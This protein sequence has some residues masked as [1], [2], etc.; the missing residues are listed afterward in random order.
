[1]ATLDTNTLASQAR[2]SRSKLKAIHIK[3]ERALALLASVVG[4][5]I[6][7]SSL[8]IGLPRNFAPADK[9]CNGVAR[10][11]HR[12]VNQERHMHF[13]PSPLVFPGG[14]EQ[15]R[16][17]FSFV[18]VGIIKW[19]YQC[20]AVAAV[21]CATCTPRPLD[22]RGAEVSVEATIGFGEDHG[23]NY[24]TI[25]ELHDRSGQL[26]AGAGFTGAY[27]T[28]IRGERLM[29]HVFFRSPSS[30]DSI[31][32]ETMPAVPGDASGFHV[33]TRQGKLY[34]FD[35]AGFGTRG[36]KLWKWDE[37]SRVW[38]PSD[39]NAPYST[40]VAGRWLS[41]LPEA[42]FYDG[43]EVLRPK[44][45]SQ[46]GVAYFAKGKL[47]TEQIPLDPRLP[48]SVVV[49]DMATL[50]NPFISSKVSFILTEPGEF[51]YTFGQTE[52][53][54]CFMSNYGRFVQ[55]S[56]G[57]FTDILAANRSEQYYCTLNYGKMLLVGSYPFGTV[58]AFVGNPVAMK[59]R[60][61]T[62]GQAA[63]QYGRETQ[64]LAIYGGDVYAGLWPWGEV[65]SAQLGAAGFSL[66]T[67][68]FTKQNDLNQKALPPV[69]LEDSW[70][71]PYE[72]TALEAGAEY[73]AA[74]QR[75]T[76]MCVYNN[77]LVLATSS[78]ESRPAKSS[79]RFLPEEL[80]NEYGDIYSLV[81][82]G[83]LS[84]AIPWTE[85]PVQ[86]SIRLSGNRLTVLSDGCVLGTT[87]LEE[88]LRVEWSGVTATFGQGIFGTSPLSIT[89]TR[90]S[91]PLDDASSV[92]N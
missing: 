14:L 62:S 65:C 4:F 34:A 75:I 10:T 42:I 52:S 50:K 24:G 87:S 58:D 51:I 12:C 56:D 8:P 80:R 32:I 25:Y 82:P 53:A 76:S 83:A 63:S 18:L 5:A 31:K 73:N 35:R 77:M 68:L 55:Y 84:V 20:I 43:K 92:S 3:V 86:L 38:Q 41:V 47:F 69:L 89:H 79:L 59:W 66:V 33:F 13:E 54:V 78:K 2:G 11:R 67:A 81:V 30:A 26:I 85:E 28:N 48:R 1:M 37:R 64:S 57:R 16:A 91:I 49:F 29:L 6:K 7:H 46:F 17:R 74:G 88:A 36:E 71:H 19:F 23:Q 45:M 44:R 40:L 15:V 21:L 9:R 22:K 60:W 70:L 90:L 39:W 27:G 72:K 61:A